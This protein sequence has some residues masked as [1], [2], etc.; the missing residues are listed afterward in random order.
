MK[1]VFMGTSEFAVPALEKMAM[2]GHDISLVLTKAP[3]KSGRGHKL[4]KSPIHQLSER[5][6]LE[7][8]TPGT[9]K[10]VEVQNIIRSENPDIIVVTSYGH[11]VPQSILDIPKYGCLNIHP[12]ILPR[13]RGAAPIERTILVNDKE[14]AVCIMKMDA[15]LDTGDV[16]TMKKVS[17]K[18]DATAESLSKSLADL[19]ADMLIKVLDNIGSITPERQSSEGVTYAHKLRKDEGIINWSDTAEKINCMVRALNPWPGCFF[20]Y[21]DEYIRILSAVI[22][23]NEHSGVPGEVLDGNMRIACGSGCLTPLEL[24]R[25]GKRPL[26][27]KDFLNGMQIRKGVVLQSD[28]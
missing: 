11:I 1:I 15:G 16:L 7:V 26:E 22:D 23:T 12:S 9:L 25:P 27:R 18:P 8:L 17:I 19:G 10:S 4:H 28:S 6:G 20:K 21:K 24:Q 5:L 14:T 3:S 13:W 2:V